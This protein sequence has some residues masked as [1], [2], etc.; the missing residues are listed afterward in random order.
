MRI[1]VG[2][3]W[4][5]LTFKRSA[6]LQGRPGSGYVGTPS[7]MTLVAPSASGP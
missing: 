1:V 2:A 5:M 7:Y 4:K 3:V 6:I